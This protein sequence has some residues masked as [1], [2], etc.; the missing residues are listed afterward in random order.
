M[1]SACFGTKSDI[2][3]RKDGSGTIA[4]EYKVSADF[5]KLGTFDG[6]Q[7]TPSIPI[8]EEDFKRT[9]EAIEGL[10]L[11]RF[12]S[13]NEDDNI[14]YDVKMEYSNINALISF[15]DTQGQHFDLTETNGKNILTVIFS[16]GTDE[17]TP[18]M[19]ELIPI[20]F[21][22]YKLD[23]KITLPSQCTVSFFNGGAQKIEGP[24]VGEVQT[25]AKTINFSSSM[26]EILEVEEPV[27]MEISWNK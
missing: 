21:D 15:M 5:M 26:S 3:L 17:Y 9:V 18:E 19:R 20:I 16:P 23:F 24:P 22:G 10:K 6:N 14:I 4:L 7:S 25:S 12:S 1:F 27:A 2:T 13:K 11:T 8:G